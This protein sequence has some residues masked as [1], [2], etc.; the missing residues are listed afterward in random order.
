[1]QPRTVVQEMKQSNLDMTLEQLVDHVLQDASAHQLDE[2][3]KLV[4]RD[5]TML[6]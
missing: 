3:R 4:K 1:M 5:A 6:V 2:I